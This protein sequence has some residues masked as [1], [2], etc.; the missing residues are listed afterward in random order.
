[1]KL[2]VSNL[3]NSEAVASVIEQLYFKN[4][5][6]DESHVVIIEHLL[7]CPIGALSLLQNQ[8]KNLSVRIGR[9][10]LT[11]AYQTKKLAHEAMLLVLEW[12]FRIGYRRVTVEVDTRHIIM[13]KFLDRCGFRQEA[14]LRKHKIFEKRNRDTALYVILNNEFHDVDLRLRKYVGFPIKPPTKK[15]AEIENIALTKP[16]NTT[17]SEEAQHSREAVSLVVKN[18]TEMVLPPREIVQG[19][20]TLHQ[21]CF[22]VKSFD[23]KFASMNLPFDRLMFPKL[24]K[25]DQQNLHLVG[26]LL[27]FCV[28]FRCICYYSKL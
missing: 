21:S 7:K 8:P 14:V 24:R 18:N 12:L 4:D 16:R 19:I 17:A 26:K 5:D 27:Y 6:D 28:R 15:V 23:A 13:R 20:V 3:V 10:W 22:E 1:V 9:M 2:S 25:W 11:P